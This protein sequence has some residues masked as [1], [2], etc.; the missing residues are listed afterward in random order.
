MIRDTIIPLSKAPMFHDMALPS[1][2][3]EYAT[4]VA[5]LVRLEPEAWP[6]A[7]RSAAK[8]DSNYTMTIY[9][10]INTLMRFSRP[11]GDAKSIATDEI[12]FNIPHPRSHTDSRA[13]PFIFDSVRSHINIL[14]VILLFAVT[15]GRR[16]LNF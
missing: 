3:P 10:G 15:D 4:E 7:A 5:L 9:S 11:R 2:E 13:Q 6:P 8:N 1:L 16:Q 12:R 14:E